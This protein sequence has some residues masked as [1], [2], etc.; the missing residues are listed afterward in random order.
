MMS[1]LQAGLKLREARQLVPGE[2]TR[3]VS[4]YLTPKT[5]FFLPR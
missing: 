4:V 2:C 5:A 3:F 1:I